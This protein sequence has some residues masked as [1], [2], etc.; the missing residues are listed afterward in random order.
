MID[1][2][3]VSVITNATSTS[4][5]YICGANPSSM[6]KLEMLKSKFQ[7][8]M[9]TYQFGLSPLHARI[10][11]ME[12]ILNLAYRLDLPSTERRSKGTENC[13]ACIF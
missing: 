6:N 7:P 1:G 4:S 2:K 11:F 9:D 5:C 12:F 10:K 13:S 3:V 8:N